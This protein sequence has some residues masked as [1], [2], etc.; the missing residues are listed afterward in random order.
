MATLLSDP[1][2][3]LAGVFLALVQFLVALPWL[4]AV[5]PKGFRATAASGSYYRL[6]QPDGSH[7]PGIYL[8]TQGAVEVTAVTTPTHLLPGQSLSPS[9]H[10]FGSC[11][12]STFTGTSLHPAPSLRC[13][14]PAPFNETLV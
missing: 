2:V 11:F 13:I 6:T 3:L 1:T 14:W 5:D 10:G 7:Q 9:W 8:I 4:Y 12:A